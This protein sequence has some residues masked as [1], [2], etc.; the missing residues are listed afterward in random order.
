VI[1]LYD[2]CIN[3]FDIDTNHTTYIYD[4]V[5]WKVAK[6]YSRLLFLSLDWVR[7]C[8]IL[9]APEWFT[10]IFEEK[11][12]NRNL[13]Q[14]LTAIY[15]TASS[16][17][18]IIIWLL[19]PNIICKQYIHSVNIL[20]CSIVVTNTSNKLVAYKN[21]ITVFCCVNGYSGWRLIIPIIR[22]SVVFDCEYLTNINYKNKKSPKFTFTNTLLF[23]QCYYNVFYFWFLFDFFL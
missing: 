9:C 21:I 23:A 8:K 13:V 22:L 14:K 1:I 2:K 4:A 16:K 18:L 19:T 5:F 7:F 12:P 11:T 17:S 10:S 6:F 3:V 15:K 20:L